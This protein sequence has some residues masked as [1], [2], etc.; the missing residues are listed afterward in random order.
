MTVVPNFIFFLMSFNSF[1]LTLI[2]E[3][4]ITLDSDEP[5]RVFTIDA[6]LSE[7]SGIFLNHFALK[8]LFFLLL[9]CI[10]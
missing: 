1:G 7:C 6:E 8:P 9:L 3:V 10:F 2:S 5:F 4:I